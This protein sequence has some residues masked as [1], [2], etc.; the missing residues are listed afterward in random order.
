MRTWA[1][2]L[3]YFKRSELACKGSGVVLLDIRF[4]VALP[5]L[6]QEWGEILHPTS[7]CRTPEHNKASGGKSDSLHLT[8]N[9]HRPSWGTMAADMS[10]RNWSTD[11]KLRFARLALKMGWSVGLHDGFVH[12]DWRTA[13]GMPRACFVYG[14]WSWAF[15]PDDVT[16]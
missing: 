1:E 9:N 15:S 6:R 2:A 11:K 8:V 4:A 12:V 7:V 16:P 14:T 5:Q 3:P 10:W 13:A